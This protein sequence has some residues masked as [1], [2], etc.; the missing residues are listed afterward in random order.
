[1]SKTFSFRGEKQK[2]NRVLNWI[3]KKSKN[4]EVTTYKLLSHGINRHWVTSTTTHFRHTLR[5]KK[6]EKYHK[7]TFVFFLSLYLVLL[8]TW[9]VVMISIEHNLPHTLVYH[10]NQYMLIELFD[11]SIQ[12][13]E[14]ERMYW[15]VLFFIHF[16]SWLNGKYEKQ[17]QI[18]L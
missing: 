15:S 18:I 6:R 13:N 10:S 3:G 1:M 12:E 17:L 16:I 14:K 5:H 8:V 11:I 2:P 9:S 7:K 4:P